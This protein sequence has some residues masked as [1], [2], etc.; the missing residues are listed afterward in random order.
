MYISGMSNN[1]TLPVSGVDR[2]TPINADNTVESSSRIKETTECQTCE[3]RKYVDGSNE[4]DVS[5][6]TPGNIKP[7]ESFAKVSAHEQQH[8]TNAIARASKPGAQLI[9]ATVT[10]KMGIC[11]ECGKSYVSGGL[12]ST[13]I[14]Y[15]ESNP[16]DKGRKLIEASFI[17]GA[18]VDE[19]I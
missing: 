2:V 14:K 1:Y 15:T 6:K 19:S 18:N 11:P 16:Y 9:S 10:L 12:T 17:A 5:F 8:V 7:E 13:Q 3:S 4:S